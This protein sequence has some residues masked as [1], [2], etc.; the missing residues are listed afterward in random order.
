MAWPIDVFV[1]YARPGPTAKGFDL[2]QWSRKLIATLADLANPNSFG[3]LGK[4][5]LAID[6]PG[7]DPP[8]DGLVAAGPDTIDDC[9]LLLVLLSPELIVDP[10]RLKEI[11]RFMQ[12]AAKDGRTIKQTVLATVSQTLVK[13]DQHPGLDWLLQRGTRALGGEGFFDPATGKSLESELA[14]PGSEPF[15]ALE[16]ALKSLAGEMRKTLKPLRTDLSDR[17]AQPAYTVSQPAASTPP[18]RA[19]PS[20]PPLAPS[21]NKAQIYLASAASETSW[22]DTRK[23][24]ETVAIVNPASWSAPPTFAMLKAQNEERIQ[25]LVSCR[26]MVLLR[27]APDDKTDIYVS[28]ALRDNDYLKEQDFPELPFVLVDWVADD[29]PELQNVAIT[30][31]TTDQA[32]WAVK[33]GKELGL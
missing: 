7:G 21:G 11:D 17:A 16:P 23:A 9:A 5:T 22:S 18:G 25:Y 27:S 24:L 32:D 2:G 14:A 8:T 31:V 6:W 26:G 19:S 4:V 28:R 13:P 3:D 33:V 29:G 1:C 15:T 12:L 20:T 10:E 30:R